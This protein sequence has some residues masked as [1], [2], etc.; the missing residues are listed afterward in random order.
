MKTIIIIFSVSVLT[1]AGSCIQAKA[2]EAPEWT[3]ACQKLRR[4]QLLQQICNPSAL[5]I[6]TVGHCQSIN[7]CMNKILHLSSQDFLK[8]KNRRNLKNHPSWNDFPAVRKISCNY[9][10]ETHG[11][12]NL[13]ALKKANSGPYCPG[14]TDSSNSEDNVMMKT[15]SSGIE[16]FNCS[17]AMKEL[18]Q[19]IIFSKAPADLQT[20]EVKPWERPGISKKVR[21][22]LY[23]SYLESK[24]ADLKKSLGEEKVLQQYCPGATVIA[25]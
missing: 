11:Q 13:C 2:E 5:K 18:V 8:L 24:N 21:D 10:M 16:N 12:Q 19:V 1:L 6:E 20:T 25:N 3:T 4:C 7:G 23:N 22:Q 9:Q 15:A 17:T 14:W